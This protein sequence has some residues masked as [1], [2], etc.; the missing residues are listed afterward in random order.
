MTLLYTVVFFQ[1]HLAT[2]FLTTNH[3]YSEEVL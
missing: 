2:W 1:D 3:E